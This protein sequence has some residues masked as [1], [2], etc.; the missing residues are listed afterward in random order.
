MRGLPILLWTL[1]LLTWPADL[2]NA[3]I[4][5]EANLYRVRKI[6]LEAGT[7]ANTDLSEHGMAVF[8]DLRPDLKEALLG[9]GFTIVDNP[10]DADAVMYGGHTSDWVVLD[11]PP[12]DPPKY[13]YQFWLLST[14]YNFRWHT[15]FNMS[16]RANESEVGR[17][18]V[19]KAAQKLFK[20]WKKSATKAG[21][22]V[23]EKLP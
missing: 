7:Q 19:Q 22:V 14:K 23:G 21:I 15:Q 11:G 8:A 3:A 16:S 4:D 13:G 17:K 12:L 5:N 20:A 2:S 1:A 10:T 18:A 6:A 9:Y